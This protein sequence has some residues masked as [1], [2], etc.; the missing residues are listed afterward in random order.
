MPGKAVAPCLHGHLVRVK[1]GV[2]GELRAL[3]G[4]KIQHVWPFRRALLEHQ[5]LG[6][7]NG[8]GVEAEGLVALLAAGNGLEDQIAGRARLYG[9]HLGR[10]MGQHADLGGNGPVLL[11]LLEPAEDFPRLLRG[12]RHRVQPDH[13][14]SRPEAQP[15][16][17]GGGD[18][19]GIVGGVVGLQAAAQGS[20]QTDG[21]IAVGGDGD[22][23]GGVDEVQVAHELAHRRCH[24]RRQS[25]AAT[26]DIGAGGVL[27]QNPFP[28]LGYRPEL[29]FFVFRQIQ[30]VLDDPGDLVGF[31]GHRR[32]LPELLQGDS[33]K[34]NLGGYTL[35]G[36][37][38]G[39]KRQFVPGFF[40]V[41]LGQD[42][43]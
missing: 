26:A 27:V 22:L 19:L 38:G 14:V 6:V 43:L 15:F 12:V 25:P 30:V 36:A 39:K 24:F 23:P 4:L 34:N 41:G 28:E 16:Q 5:R 18:A 31:V 1:V 35:L 17:D 29:Y 7:G 37:L 21:G 9:L 11:D 32:M 33:G 40:L 10:H 13:R 3:A 42:L 20:R 2:A 8:L